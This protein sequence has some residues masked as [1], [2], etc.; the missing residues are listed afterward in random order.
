MFC[1]VFRSLNC[2]WYFPLWDNLNFRRDTIDKPAQPFFSFTVVSSTALCYLFSN[3]IDVVV[4]N[5]SVSWYRT[6]H[7]RMFVE[8]DRQYKQIKTHNATYSLFKAFVVVPLLLQLAFWGLQYWLEI[9]II[10][11]S[12]IHD[13]CWRMYSSFD[14]RMLRPKQ[15]LHCYGLPV[16]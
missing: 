13:V 8:C 14:R 3:I 16:V 2:F 5:V 10:C 11:T 9:F 6:H 12:F 15:I 4:I 1:G 7:V